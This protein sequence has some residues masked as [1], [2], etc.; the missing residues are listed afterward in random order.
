MAKK[1]GS[2]ERRNYSLISSILMGVSALLIEESDFFWIGVVGFAL[3]QIVLSFIS[4]EEESWYGEWLEAEKEKLRKNREHIIKKEDIKHSREINRL[5]KKSENINP[6]KINKEY[7]SLDDYKESE[8][9][10]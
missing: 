6:S 5:N 2:R 10:E 9:D 1:L 4:S 7:T 3:V 8:K